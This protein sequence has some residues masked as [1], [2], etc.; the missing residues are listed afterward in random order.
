[1]KTKN[2]LQKVLG[3]EGAGAL[4]K[5]CERDPVLEP[6]LIPRTIISWLD[7]IAFV[8]YEGEIPGISDSYISLNK[9]EN[10]YS[11]KITVGDIVYPFENVE[12]F[13][14]AASVGMSLGIDN[15]SIS[16]ELKSQDLSKLGQSID[17]LVKA[18][19]FAQELD[20]S[21]GE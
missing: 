15:C 16:P 12:V 9:N 18:R 5:A 10:R 17:L 21:I 19:V 14:V 13:H 6:A 1:M 8:G 2:F 7:S 11:G 4:I 20:S 3:T